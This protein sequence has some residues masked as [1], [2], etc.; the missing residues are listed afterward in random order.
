MIDSKQLLLVL[1]RLST[2][3]GVVVDDFVFA[4]VR[5]LRDVT[6]PVPDSR[7]LSCRTQRL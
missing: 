3:A 7:L 6:Y 4:F 5:R 2:I 1:M